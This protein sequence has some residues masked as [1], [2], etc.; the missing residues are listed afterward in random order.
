MLAFVFIFKGP[1]EILEIVLNFIKKVRISSVI[2]NIHFKIFKFFD[3]INNTE[4]IKIK[5]PSESLSK[6]GK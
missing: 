1:F 5:I 6:E 3:N 2:K 4:S